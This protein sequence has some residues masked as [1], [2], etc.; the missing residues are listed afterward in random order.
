MLWFTLASWCVYR[1]TT[2]VPSATASASA[3]SRTGL[4]V[5]APPISCELAGTTMNSFIAIAE[6]RK[7]LGTDPVDKTPLTV[8]SIKE[9]D[10]GFLVNLGPADP[11]GL[12]GG[13]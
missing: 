7:A 3:N 8:Y 9:V 2:I 12:G 13:G 1:L 11:N 4:A 6:A 10:N 5:I